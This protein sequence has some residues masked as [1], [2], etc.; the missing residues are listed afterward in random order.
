[1]EIG[2]GVVAVSTNGTPVV[3]VFGTTAPFNGTITDIVTTA[4]DGTAGN[5]TTK[6]G[7]DTVAVIA[8]GTST[9]GQV[10][11]T[12]LSNASFVAGDVVTVESSVTAL[13][14]GQARVKIVF[15]AD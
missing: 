6:V 9:G 4:L 5:I 14:G 7:S 12:T 8:K 3:N 13:G 1:M 10:G 15:T 2:N 11:A